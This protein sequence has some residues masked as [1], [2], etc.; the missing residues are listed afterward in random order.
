MSITLFW[1]QLKQRFRRLRY[2]A[3]KDWLNRRN[4]VLFFAIMLCLIWTYGAITS[5]SKNWQLADK[6]RTRELEAKKLK[7]EIETLRLEQT[8][9]KSAE[10]QE[11]MARTKQNKLLPGEK[12]LIL[13]KNS[14]TAT[15]KY[16]DKPSAKL[17]EH[18]FAKWLKFLFR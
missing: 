17:P 7:L 12:M 10:Y 1:P 6:L 5:L 13:P 2:F 15:S 8:Y 9:F 4:L 14:A 11:L 16:A 18:N 3:R